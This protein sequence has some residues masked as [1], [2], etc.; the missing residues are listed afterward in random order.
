MGEAVIDLYE[1]EVSG[2][3]VSHRQCLW[4]RTSQPNLE[5]LPAPGNVVG[6][7]RMAFGGTGDVNRAL[8]QIACAL[9]R[10]EDHR[11]GAVSLEATVEEP[12]WFGNHPSFEII[13]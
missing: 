7:Q 11:A 10:T 6:R 13:I 12:E 4:S 1:I 5:K 8:A 9:C 2:L 3:D